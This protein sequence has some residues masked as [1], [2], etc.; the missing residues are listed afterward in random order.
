MFHYSD[1]TTIYI[2]SSNPNLKIVSRFLDE[3]AFGGGTEPGDYETVVL[4]P[5][6]PFLKIETSIDTT[7]MDK[8]EWIRQIYRR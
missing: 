7:K 3:G 1:A 8:G 4:R 5:I 6:T 2:S